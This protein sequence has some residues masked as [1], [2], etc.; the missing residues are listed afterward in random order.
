M[1]LLTNGKSDGGYLAVELTVDKRLE[2]V[3]PFARGPVVSWQVSD[4]VLESLQ[5]AVDE[6]EEE[7]DEPESDW[8]PS[9]KIAHH[10][11]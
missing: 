3:L 11:R 10:E 7:W 5:E 2:P 1:A 6:M 9:G 4:E 8:P